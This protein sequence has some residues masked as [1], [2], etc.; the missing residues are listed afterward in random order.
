MAKRETV[1]KKHLDA[2]LHSIATETD[3]VEVQIQDQVFCHRAMID[4]GSDWDCLG[5]N[6]LASLGR[7]IK[8]LCTLWLSFASFSFCLQFLC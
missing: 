8:S 5:V 1:E 6:Q 2:V 4:T 7:T 3:T